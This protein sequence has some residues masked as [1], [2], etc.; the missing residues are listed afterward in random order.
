MDCGE[1]ES[2]GKPWWVFWGFLGKSLTLTSFLG[3]LGKGTGS[4]RPEL[5]WP[6]PF[7]PIHS[8]THY[9]F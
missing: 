2:V 6:T 8:A 9:A 3:V 7:A 4:P 1:V 5:R